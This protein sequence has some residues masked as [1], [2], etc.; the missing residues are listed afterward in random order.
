MRY[1]KSALAA[2]NFLL[3]AELRAAW[4]SVF[5]IVA[6]G[7][8]IR[9][10]SPL[11]GE[12]VES[13]SAQSMTS[14]E[15]PDKHVDESR[16]RGCRR[17]AGPLGDLLFAAGID[18]LVQ[19]GIRAFNLEVKCAMTGLFQWQNIQSW[20][21]LGATLLRSFD[22]G[23]LSISNNY[24]GIK[25]SYLNEFG[26]THN[27]RIQTHLAVLLVLEKCG[28]SIETFRCSNE[29][30][31]NWPGSEVVPLLICNPWDCLAILVSTTLE[32]AT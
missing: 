28:Q 18:S 29:I 25:I 3:S 22:L 31:W 10:A 32:L 2:K 9:F 11:C 19:A 5:R 4:A 15:R 27:T 30:L 24:E 8:T 12:S 16:A 17:L 13:D 26:K 21:Q 20:S 23:P 7:L 6:N 14:E 1:G